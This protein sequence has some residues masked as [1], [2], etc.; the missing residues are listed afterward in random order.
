MQ[1]LL[2]PTSVLSLLY[3]EIMFA[4]SFATRFVRKPAVL[5]LLCLSIPVNVPAT[6]V[7]N[8]SIP[9]ILADKQVKPHWRAPVLIE[10]NDAGPA[11]SPQIAL[12]AVGNAIAVWQQPDGTTQSIWANRYEIGKGWGTPQLLESDNAG[13]AQLPQVAVDGAG[14]ALVV[15]Q[16]SDGSRNNIWA[17]RYQVETGWGTPQLLETDNAGDAQSPKIALNGAGNAIA[18][19]RQYDGSVGYIWANRYEV[20]KDWGTPQLISNATGF[21][22]SGPEI[23]ADAAGNAL[24]VWSQQAVPNTALRVWQSS[25]SVGSGWETAQAIDTNNGYDAHAPTVALNAAGNHA[26][27]AWRQQDETWGYLLYARMRTEDWGEAVRIYDDYVST[28]SGAML[29]VDAAG[30]VMASWKEGYKFASLK[31]NRYEPGTGWGTPTVLIPS[32]MDV[33]SPDLGMDAEGNV[34]LVCELRPRWTYYIAA[35]RYK[36]GVDWS[37]STPQLI[38]PASTPTNSSGVQLAVHPSGSAVAVWSRA[39]L[40]GVNIYAARYE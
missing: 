37:T 3:G 17:N 32:I 40:T 19:W 39:E 26:V 21:L 13:N 30:N 25:Y 9:A 36:V 1:A 7:L 24:V 33:S 15:W 10:T 18:V 23:A 11:G 12:D 29:S 6:S 14:N 27:V 28:L 34:L 5:T 16:Q 8:I 31:A 20:G 4:P 38:E 22:W 35:S 2:V